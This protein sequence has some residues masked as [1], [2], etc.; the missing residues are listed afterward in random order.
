MPS[1][2]C[3]LWI[4]T[5]QTPTITSMVLRNHV[6]GQVGLV[7]HALEEVEIRSATIRFH[8]HL[9]QRRLK[10]N[11]AVSIVSQ[12]QSDNKMTYLNDAQKPL[13]SFTSTSRSIVRA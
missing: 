1:P 7:S 2:S 3:N 10:I 13:G 4:Q 9:R 12:Q 8:A 5:S 11:D 6:V